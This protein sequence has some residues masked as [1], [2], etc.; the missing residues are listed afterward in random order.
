M[1]GNRHEKVDDPDDYL[2]VNTAGWDLLSLLDDPGKP[3]PETAR[4]T[5]DPF[6]WIEWEQVKRVLCLAGG[7]GSFA[8]LFACLGYEVTVFDL[9]EGQLECDRQVGR[10]EGLDI[11]CVQG[12]MLD[13]SALGS[14][15]FDLVYQP[16]SAC[17]IPDARRMYGQVAGVTRQG[18]SYIVKHW[19]PVQLQ[20]AAEGAW[21]GSA[22]RIDRPAWTEQPLLW[23]S[24]ETWSGKRASCLHYIHRLDVLIGGICDAGFEIVGFREPD[25]GDGTAEPLTDAHMA[26]YFPPF[27]WIGA[28]RRAD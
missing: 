20:V 9:S 1:S 5:L 26:A 23:H 27:L 12:D 6:G 22:Y 11:E 17:Y 24:D 16:I 25:L 2:S 8:P 18:A 10:E 14:Q 7:G 4:S 3:D 15:R 13:L 19:S 28:R 21:D